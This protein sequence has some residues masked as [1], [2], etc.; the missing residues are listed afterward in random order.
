[1]LGWFRRWSRAGIKSQPFTD[2]QSRVLAEQVP[3]SLRLNGDKHDRFR[4]TVQVLLS[5][6]SFEGCDGLTVTDEMRLTVCG[7][8]AMM[9]LGVQDYYFEGVTSILLYPQSFKRQRQGKWSTEEVHNAGEAWQ[10]GP[11]I[12]SWADC[13]VHSP[14]RNHG[15]NVIVHEFAHHLDGIDGE[16]GGSIQMP[17]SQDQQSWDDIA[18][19]EL[20]A[21]QAKVQR[22]QNSVLDPYGATNQAEFFAVA[23]EAF[24]EI[25][26][27]LEEEHEELF[28]L[29][30]VYYQIDP[31]QWQA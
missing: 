29:L 13:E 23:S 27:Q 5:E 11:I 26:T 21:L 25:P 17:T 7:N 14:L 19:Q 22:R 28:R 8:A 20:A 9:L 12:L 3:Q 24:F 1:M 4:Q 10:Y 15:R 30:M 18:E 31:R 16:M 2:Q 6:Q